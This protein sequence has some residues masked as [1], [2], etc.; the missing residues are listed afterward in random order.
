MIGTKLFCCCTL[1]L[2]SSLK[3]YDR[4]LFIFYIY[5]SLLVSLIFPLKLAGAL[6]QRRQDK[7]GKDVKLWLF[8]LQCVT[9]IQNNNRSNTN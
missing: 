2:N 3:I 8:F 4:D 5:I 9:A 6:K 7:R 1:L